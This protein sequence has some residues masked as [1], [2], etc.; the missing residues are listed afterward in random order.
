LTAAKM[1]PDMDSLCN[2]ELE[3]EVNVP[4]NT[5]IFAVQSKDQVDSLSVS[6]RSKLRPRNFVAIPPFLLATVNEAIGISNGDAAE[7]LAAAVKGIKEFDEGHRND[8][9]Y[10]DKAKEKCVEFVS[11]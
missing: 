9:D 4:T 10:V 6:T 3:D 2:V 11:R 1:T 7:V 8:E 5:N